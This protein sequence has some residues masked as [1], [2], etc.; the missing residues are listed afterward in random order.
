V[1][2][3][4]DGQGAASHVGLIVG[5]DDQTLHVLGGN[6]GSPGKVSTVDFPAGRIRATRIMPVPAPASIAGVDLEALRR[7][8]ATATPDDAD[9]IAKAPGIMHDLIRDLPGLTP[10]QAGGILGN[11]GHECGGFRQLLQIGVAEGKGGMGWCQ[12]DGARREAFLKF[13]NDRVK[14]W[15]SPEVNYDY[16]V[17]E[18]RTS[19]DAAFRELL[20]QTSLEAAVVSFDACFER[21]G[22][23]ALEKRVRYGRLAMLAFGG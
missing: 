8:G 5:N 15:R 14:P 1:V 17:H 2:V 7:V 4:N 13:A 3:L 23:K 20:R 19:E 6:Q 16:L 18:L 9:F 22:V 12:W 11:I 10:V 21:S